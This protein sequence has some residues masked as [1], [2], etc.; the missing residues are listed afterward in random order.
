MLRLGKTFLYG[1]GLVYG[2]HFLV[3]TGN[4]SFPICCHKVGNTL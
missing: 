3:G 2:G 1:P 4:G